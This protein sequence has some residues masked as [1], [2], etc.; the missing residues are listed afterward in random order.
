[1]AR[2]FACALVSLGL[3][4]VPVPPA[5]AARA[6]GVVGHLSACRADLAEDLRSTGRASQLMT[7]T[8]PGYETSV[9]EAELW[10][11]VGGCWVLSYGPWQALI[12]LSGFSDHH[13]EGD[14]TTPTGLYPLG[15]TVYGNQPNAGYRGPYHRLICGDWWDEDPT[16]R[17]YNSFQHV[18]CG[19]QPPFAGSSE[20]LWTET[21]YYPALVVVEYNVDPVV[22]YAGSG[23]FVHASVGAPTTGCVSIPLADLWLFLRWLNPSTSAAIAMGPLREFSRF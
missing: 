17:T 22:P 18:P 19:Q 2:L 15:K 13:R 4:W 7:L 3:A 8:S 14:G 11:R 6:G 5:P 20:P 21:A 12:G 16:S 23:I 1:V 10:Q 9:A